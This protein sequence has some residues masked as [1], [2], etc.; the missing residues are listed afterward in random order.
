MCT[1]CKLQATVQVCACCNYAAL[2]LACTRAPRA[3]SPFTANCAPAWPDSAAA[4]M[5]CVRQ[6]KRRWPA[7]QQRASQQRAPVFC[8]WRAGK[9]V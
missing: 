4:F 7:S 1:N 6:S 2:Q 3:P 9:Y 5:R 8:G